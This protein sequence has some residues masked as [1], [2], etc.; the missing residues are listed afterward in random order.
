MHLLEI[1]K[2]N[3]DIKITHYK[4]LCQY[5]VKGETELCRFVK[6]DKSPKGKITGKCIL[7]ESKLSVL[8]NMDIL[9]I[10]RCNKCTKAFKSV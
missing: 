9:H 5:N 1:S 10:S 7:F 4:V 6:L 8:D 2:G 3:P